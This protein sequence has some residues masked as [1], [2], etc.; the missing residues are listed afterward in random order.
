MSLQLVQ[1]ISKDAETI[2]RLT[3]LKEQ[4]AR[5]ITAVKSD[6]PGVRVTVE[7]RYR[8]GDPLTGAAATFTFDGDPLP[9]LELE[10]AEAS[11]LLAAAVK[12]YES[13]DA[14]GELQLA[15]A[16]L[17]VVKAERDSLKAEQVRGVE[18]GK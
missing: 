14:I 11:E 7:A 5:L 18:E 9:M 15:K 10:L 3:S 4:L 17:E 8:N 12:P 13:R 16:E 1:Q 6:R 2:Q